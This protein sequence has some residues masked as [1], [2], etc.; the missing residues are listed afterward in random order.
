MKK[1]QGFIPLKIEIGNRRERYIER[2]GNK[3]GKIKDTT[4]KKKG[5]VGTL[6]GHIYLVIFCR[7]TSIAIPQKYVLNSCIL[8][9]F[10]I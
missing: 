7:T 2:K 8:S 1:V 6:M 4:A 10:F 9:V 5:K 3:K